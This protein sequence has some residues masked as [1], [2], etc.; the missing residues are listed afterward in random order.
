MRELLASG[1]STELVVLPGRDQYGRGLA[2][3]YVG[4]TDI[5]AI[6]ISE[7]LANPY[8]GGQRGDW[9]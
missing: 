4:L 3:L 7:G 9:C 6:L 5:G 1:V 2:R 8:D